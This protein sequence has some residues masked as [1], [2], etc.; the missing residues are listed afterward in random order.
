MNIKTVLKSL[1]LAA[2]LSSAAYGA[3]VA[4][5]IAISDAIVRATPPGQ[6]QTAVY[7][8]LINKSTATHR[9]VNAFAPVAKQVQIHTSQEK[10]GVFSMQRV[11]AIEIPAN[12]TVS[13]APGGLHIMLMGLTQPIAVGDKLPITLLFEDGSHQQVTA[14]VQAM[15]GNKAHANH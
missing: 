11:T 5:N 10:N 8:T 3:T 6:Q 15:T 13:L 2:C 14:V 4:E 7:L 1:V 12:Q 9:L